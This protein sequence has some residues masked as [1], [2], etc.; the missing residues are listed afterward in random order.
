MILLQIQVLSGKRDE[1]QQQGNK[2]SKEICVF[3]EYLK[4]LA[5]SRLPCPESPC[6]S[7]TGKKQLEGCGCQV[8]SLYLSF[9]DGEA[10]AC[11]LGILSLGRMVDITFGRTVKTAEH[12]PR[13][14]ADRP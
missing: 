3:Q 1:Q 5:S 4:Q 8:Q 14:G 12:S 9:Q 2:Q 7:L 10:S 11:V 6:D 13:P